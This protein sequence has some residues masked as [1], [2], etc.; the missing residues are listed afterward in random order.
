[1]VTVVLG[2]ADYSTFA[3]PHS[4]IDVKDFQT[5]R[6]LAVYLQYLI[7]N[8]AEYLSYFWWKP[9]YKVQLL[10][11]SPAESNHLLIS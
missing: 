8:P 2:G 6:D 1:M 4:Y 10:P 11:Y 3:P 5:A 7:E 9:H